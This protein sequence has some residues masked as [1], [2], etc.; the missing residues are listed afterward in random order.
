MCLTPITLHKYS[1]VDRRFHDTVV[2]CCVCPECIKKRQSEIV[3][4]SLIECLKTSSLC[5]FTLTYNNSRLP[6]T[7]DGEI[8]LRREDVKNWKK[9]FRKIISNRNFSWFCCGEYSP[10]GEHRPHYH[11]LIFGLSDSDLKLV[12]HCWSD[13]YGFTMFKKVSAVSQADVMRVARYVSKYSVKDVGF[14]Y[15]SSTV[16]KPRIMTSIGFG[17]PDERF[18]NYVLCKDK[19]DYDPFVQSS[20]SGEIVLSVMERL[21]YEF[22]GFH[23]SI[24]QYLLRKYLYAKNYKGNLQKCPLLKMVSFVVR[25]RNENIHYRAFQQFL[26]KNLSRPFNEVVAEFNNLQEMA[27]A[28]RFDT[29][30]KDILSTY[31]KSVI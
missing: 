12:E 25:C 15:F 3:V 18:W 13:K 31:K 11:G 16:E 21:H 6:H 7:E 10:K 8:T 14:K 29:Q 23:Y 27:T 17:C 30:R 26:S 9:D 5:F 2:P 20:I 4:R 1:R 28:E 24:P 22:N 19:F